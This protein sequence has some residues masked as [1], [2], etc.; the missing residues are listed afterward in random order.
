MGSD[1]SLGLFCHRQEAGAS[2]RGA[3]AGPRGTGG[4]L[5]HPSCHEPLLGS[6]KPRWAPAG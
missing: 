5:A 6:P 4:A 1:R 2:S 3:R